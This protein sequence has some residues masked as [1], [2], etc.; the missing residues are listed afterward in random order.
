M[1]DAAAFTIMHGRGVR[2]PK[3]PTIEYRPGWEVEYDEWAMR[4]GKAILWAAG[5]EPKLHLRFQP[6]SPQWERSELP[7][8]AATLQW[9][10]AHASAVADITLRRDD[11]QVIVR[12][13]LTLNEQSGN[14]DISVPLVRSGKYYLDVVARDAAASPVSPVAAGR[15]LPATRSPACP[16]PDWAEIGENLSGSSSCQRRSGAEDR[17]VVSL[18][19][20]RDREIA[21]R[22]VNSDGAKSAFHFNVE[23]WFPM[24]LEVRATLMDGKQ[25]VAS[26]WQFAR[27]VQRH[28]G[29]FNF[30]MWDTPRGNLA[31]WAEQALAETGVTV[32]LRGGNP[33][34]WVAAYDIAWIPYTTHIGAPCQPVCWADEDKI[35]AHVDGIVEK[36]IAARQHGVFAYSLG[37]EIV[38]RGSCLSPHCLEAYREYLQEQYGDIAAL[39]ASW[40]SEYVELR[41]RC[42]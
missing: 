5:K 34:P 37:D 31:P 17:V 8:A 2:L 11:G 33:E 29:Q 18:I 38:V 24:L 4:L 15:H 35:Q 13:E 16:R 19:D 22:T 27:V 7:A 1:D 20:R 41:R 6:K 32:H 3:R 21:R 26:A 28:R 39:N 10:G 42:N 23:P 9:Q 14:H 25:E 30:V 40:G 36:H 12:E